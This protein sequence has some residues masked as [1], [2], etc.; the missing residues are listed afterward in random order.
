MPQK[1]TLS[2]GSITSATRLPRAAA[3]SSFVGLRA[4]MTVFRGMTVSPPTRLLSWG[5][6]PLLSKANRPSWRQHPIRSANFVSGRTSSKG[7]PA[8]SAT[9]IRT[10][11]ATSSSVQR[12]PPSRWSR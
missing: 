6:R 7:S 4:G 2:P 9:T 12:Q 1:S 3:I 11:A 8:Q 10:L 5:V